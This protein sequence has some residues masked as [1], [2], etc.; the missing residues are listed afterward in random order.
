M[1]RVVCLLLAAACLFLASCAPALQ[2][3]ETFAMNTIVTQSFYTDDD[4]V[5][6]ENNAILREIENEMSKTV[7]TS[8]V[9]RM[10]AGGAVEISAQTAEVLAA[11]LDA[12]E[13]TNGAFNPALGAVMDAWG[14]GTDGA[15]VPDKDA[16][17][18]ALAASDYSS[19]SLDG[20]AAGTGGAA[21]DLGGAVKGYALDRIAQNLAAH[22]VSSALISLGGS[23]YAVGEKPGGGSYKIGVR[24]PEGGENDY[25]AVLTLDGKFASTSGVYERGF[26]ENGKFYHHIIDPKT[27][28]PVENGLTAVTVICGSGLL[29]D[30]YST[31]LFVMGA[32]EGKAF[33]QEHGVDALFLTEDKTVVTTEGF[34][35]K[36]GL[37]LKNRGYRMG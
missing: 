31:A 20:T 18:E 25:M 12:A 23:I 4:A 30:I 13:E 17:E 3:S 28:Y 19:V 16:L 1:K 24:D 2:K 35:E 7:D 21:L 32:E 9:S 34:Q 15:H 6:K 27:G 8:D 22:D 33:A 5:L 26:E 10:N 36:Y 11:A 29:S 37:E 14:F